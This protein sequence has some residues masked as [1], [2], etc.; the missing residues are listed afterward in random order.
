MPNK[1]LLILQIQYPKGVVG[2][3]KQLK[4]CRPRG[5]TVKPNE[6][7]S[8]FQLQMYVFPR[9]TYKIIVEYMLASKK[10]QEVIQ[11]Q[12]CP[13]CLAPMTTWPAFSPVVASNAGPKPGP[14][15]GICMQCG[16]IFIAKQS[17]EM[18]KNQAKSNII[19]PA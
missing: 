12:F 19:L 9:A 3:R 8:G 7:G 18:L 17:L 15:L 6:D 2:E 13:A 4:L 1:Q 10:F 11:V 16:A 5:A 14:A